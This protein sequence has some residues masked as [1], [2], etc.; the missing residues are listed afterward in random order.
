MSVGRDYIERCSTKCRGEVGGRW[1]RERRVLLGR[2]NVGE[3][4]HCRQHDAVPAKPGL[5]VS[6]L[7]KGQKKKNGGKSP[8]SSTLRLLGSSA[9]TTEPAGV[10]DID[11][12]VENTS[13]GA[14]F[15]ERWRRWRR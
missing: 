14:K 1:L 7:D 13:V 3:A 6:K 2:G 5:A 12:P 10:L 15:S 11:V 8:T 9:E 4:E